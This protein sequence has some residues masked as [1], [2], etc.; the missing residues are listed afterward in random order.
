VCDKSEAHATAPSE[1]SDWEIAPH[2]TILSNV[3]RSV[4]CVRGGARAKLMQSACQF[5]KNSS[6]ARGENY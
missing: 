3:N 4:R 1:R 5:K 2:E 6:Q